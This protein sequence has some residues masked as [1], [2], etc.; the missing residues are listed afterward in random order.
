MVNKQNFINAVTQ[1]IEMVKGDTLE[2]AI[3][4]QG[5]EAAEPTITFSCA[6]NYYSEPLFVVDTEDGIE[7]VSYDD[8]NDVATYTIRV[9]PNHTEDLDLNR[10]YYD[11]EMQLNDE[12]ITLMRGRL[13]LVYEVTKGA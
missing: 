5:L 4:L 9:A 2:F 1:D 6:L 7:R 3:Q 12:V 10:Y 13:T 8:A 11:L